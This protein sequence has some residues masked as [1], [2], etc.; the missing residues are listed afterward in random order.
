[1][2]LLCS[3]ELKQIFIFFLLNVISN[4][5]CS[6][7]L[8]QDKQKLFL[9]RQISNPLSFNGKLLNYFNI[10]LVHQNFRSSLLIYP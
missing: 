8:T 6:L 1:M 7:F 9:V 10:G 5:S 3:H 2:E 4:F